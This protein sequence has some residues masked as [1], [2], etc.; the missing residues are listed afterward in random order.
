[1]LL[2]M[3]RLFIFSFFIFFV[4]GFKIN[5]KRKRESTDGIIDAKS[6]IDH[7]RKVLSKYFG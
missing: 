4:I 1:M 3:K 2:I 5:L 6:V 7:K